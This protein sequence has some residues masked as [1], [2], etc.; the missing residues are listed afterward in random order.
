MTR[1]T[2]DLTTHPWRPLLRLDLGLVDLEGYYPV[3]LCWVCPRCQRR[4]WA[5][6][7]VH[8]TTPPLTPAQWEGLTRD[9]TDPWTQ[10]VEAA[11]RRARQGAHVH[12]ALRASVEGRR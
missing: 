9:R 10:A 3:W 6:G 11:R 12:A 7:V 8:Q 2:P 5:D 1:C 4:V